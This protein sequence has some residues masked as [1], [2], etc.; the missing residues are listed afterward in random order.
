MYSFYTIYRIT[1]LTNSKTYIGQHM[2]N[3]ILD[4]Y[5]GSGTELLKDQREIGIDNFKKEILYVYDNFYDMNDKEIE[6]VNEDFVNDEISYNRMIGGSGIK[7]HKIDDELKDRFDKFYSTLNESEFD[8]FAH[9]HNKKMYDQIKLKNNISRSVPQSTL[10]N[11]EV[12]FSKIASQY[13]DLVMEERMIG[14]DKLKINEF[15]SGLLQM[16]DDLTEYLEY[17]D[18]DTM[19]KY[20]FWHT[21]IKEE[22]EIKRLKTVL[23]K[24]GFVTGAKINYKELPILLKQMYTDNNIEKNPKRTI[25]KLWFKVNDRAEVNGVR[26]YHLI[27]KK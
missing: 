23:H 25:L 1:N 3:N 14:S 27:D 5:M 11:R 21:K 13:Y 20:S 19:A 4:G 26:H 8:E 18:I 17:L 22:Y 24:Y 7:S 10:L 6:L 2:T 12:P 15:K 9:Y 16:S